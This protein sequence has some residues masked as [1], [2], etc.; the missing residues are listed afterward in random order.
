MMTM[1]T[2]TEGCVLACICHALSSSVA[3]YRVQEVHTS[4][5]GSPG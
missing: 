1:A 2:H 5:Q 4:A 3:A